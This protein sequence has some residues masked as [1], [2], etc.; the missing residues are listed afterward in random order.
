M[1]IILSTKTSKTDDRLKKSLASDSI[2]HVTYKVE[3]KSVYKE[4][5]PQHSNKRMSF[6]V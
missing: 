3:L 4:Y 2:L 1:Q 5:Y 6:I